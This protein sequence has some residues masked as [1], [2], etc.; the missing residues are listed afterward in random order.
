VKKKVT[1]AFT[2][3]RETKE[4]QQQLGGNPEVCTVYQY[5]YFMFE[6]QDEALRERKRACRA[7]EILCG[8][9][10][11]ELAQR[12]IAYLTDHQKKREKA[13]DM[14]DQFLLKD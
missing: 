7:G 5:Y 8:H 2:G 9:C 1:N 10:K 4:E 6:P 13:R 12:I 14:L 11:K 3:G